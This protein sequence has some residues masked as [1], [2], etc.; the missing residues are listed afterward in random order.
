MDILRHISA[1]RMLGYMK[2]APK[3]L[4]YVYSLLAWTLTL[5]A[6]VFRVLARVYSYDV[7]VGYF[8]SNA[9]FPTLH[10]ICLALIATLSGSALILFRHFSVPDTVIASM[11]KTC[12]MEKIA[13]FV[14]A[15]SMLIVSICTAIFYWSTGSLTPSGFTVFGLLS[16]VLSVFFFLFFFVPSAIGKNLHL[17][18][19]FALV[20][21]FVYVL[22]SSYFELYTPMNNP[23][24]LLIQLTAI[25]AV[26]YLLCDLRFYLG[27]ARPIRFIA[28]ST[29]FLGFSVVAVL[30]SGIFSVMTEAYTKLYYL[31][32]LTAFALLLP[33]AVRITRMLMLWAQSGNTPAPL[34]DDEKGSDDHEV[35]SYENDASQ[36]ASKSNDGATSLEP[37][38]GDYTDESINARKVS[39][40]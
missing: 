40:E 17:F 25:A 7:E 6:L 36:T 31:Y 38:E 2:K 37:D 18:S 26:L 30:S 16:A 21:H 11:Q 5:L 1:E 29:L 24:K 23:V 28:V 34:E 19:G 33:A 12:V 32:A 22:I 10:Y 14:G 39:E 13:A 3:K 35:Q 4:I 27:I 15:I 8:E 20:L 9:L